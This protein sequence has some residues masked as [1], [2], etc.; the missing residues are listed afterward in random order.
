MSDEMKPEARIYRYLC[1]VTDS[2]KENNFFQA[3]EDMAALKKLLNGQS[4]AAAAEIQKRFPDI[5]K[6]VKQCQKETAL[7]RIRAAMNVLEPLLP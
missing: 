5:A 6:A 2:I 3:D 7:Q 4:G 1:S